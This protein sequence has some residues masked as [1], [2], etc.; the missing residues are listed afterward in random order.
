MNIAAC[1]NAAWLAS[2][3]PAWTRFRRALQ[4]PEKTQHDILRQLLARNADSAF[5][6]A[7]GF[8]GIRTYEEFRAQV[9]VTDYDTLA[10]WVTRIARG[11]GAVLTDEPVTRLLPTSGT[12]SGRK[13]IPF[14]VALQREFNAAIG[15]WMVDLFQQHPTL[16]LGPAYW[17]ISPA[18]Q[19]SREKWAVPI[20]FDDD[21]AYLGGL[22]QRLVEAVLAVG[23]TVRLIQ[24]LE[25]ARYITLLSLLRQRGLRLISVWHPSF[26]TRLL[27]VLP[28]HWDEL[29]RDIE[30]GDCP[31]AA[32][33]PAHVR[34]VAS[35]A[36]QPGRAA[37]LRR[38]GRDDPHQLWPALRVI[39]CWADAQAALPARDLQNRLP[40]VVVQAKGLL[41]TEAFVSI[42]FRHLHPVAIG[43]H[44]YEFMD[45]RGAVRLAHELERGISY[46]VLVTT[47]GGLWRYPL[48]DRV[49]VDGFVG[50]TPSLRF[51]GRG[52]S[53]SDLCGE[54][55]E[56]AFV[57]RA[58][59]TA[60]AACRFAPR[61]ALLAPENDRGGW[62]YTLFIEGASGEALAARLDAALRANP[63][64]AHCRDLGQLGPLQLFHIRADAHE[65]FLTTAVASGRRLGEV[66]P[67]SLSVHTDWRRRFESVA[68]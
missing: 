58:I 16:A 51:L 39:S 57:T 25:C 33:L 66:K 35:A 13:L 14:T 23:P 38:V 24:D 1:A 19:P 61:F 43:S 18:V 7:H 40:R 27:D 48:G 50:R 28:A 63:H 21:S 42:P 8:S 47:G 5:G 32:A 17:S 22:R 49:E 60:C 44:F 10:P 11:E 9:P 15:P 55:L 65:I 30:C 59:E 45:E 37:H 12:T 4:E 67:Q 20:G 52:E 26:L 3:L 6:R 68:P 53:V 31:R 36:P 29:L 62:R 41:A 54:K 34:R 56:E 64:Y 2:S 46:R